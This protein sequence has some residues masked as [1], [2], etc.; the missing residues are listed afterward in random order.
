M[1]LI[2]TLTDRHGRAVALH[3]RDDGAH[4]YSLPGLELVRAARDDEGALE[5]MG[6]HDET[7][8]EAAP[9]D[10]GDVPPPGPGEALP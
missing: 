4:V 9:V 7:P 6:M 3:Q 1:N 5:L 10:V 8:V 2:D